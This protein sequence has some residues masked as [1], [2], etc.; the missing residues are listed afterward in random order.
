MGKT[1]GFSANAAKLNRAARIGLRRRVEN[2]FVP[3]SDTTPPAPTFE[4]FDQ[5]IPA[6]KCD[7]HVYMASET[8]KA[9]VYPHNREYRFIE[10]LLPDGKVETIY[11]G[12]NFLDSRTVIED[13]RGEIIGTIR[14]NHLGNGVIEVR[15]FDDGS[16]LTEHQAPED[17]DNFS[18]RKD[19][20]GRITSLKLSDCTHIQF[21]Y[22]GDD[23][24]PFLFTDKDGVEWRRCPESLVYKNAA[25]ELLGGVRVQ[26][27]AANESGSYMHSSFGRFT[28][29][30]RNGETEVRYFP[31]VRDLLDQEFPVTV[32][33]RSD[34]DVDR[35]EDFACAL[36]QE[37]ESADIE[38]A[39][40][41]C[42]HVDGDIVEKRHISRF[43]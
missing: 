9:G 43:Y 8:L 14:A 12:P 21:A 31:T 2:Q 23:P 4:Y 33:V 30:H 11:S 25:G 32:A 7:Y 42:E 24:I 22:G 18:Y 26:L 20:K 5:A 38:V 16:T 10:R 27:V 36:R 37:Y 3:H 17:Q 29:M 41:S 6:S 15:Y 34:A 35:A 1:I 39:V 13:S 28:V 19:W 40:V